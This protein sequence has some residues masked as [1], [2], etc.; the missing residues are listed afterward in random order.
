MDLSHL[1]PLPLSTFLIIYIKA[2]R[3]ANL[4]YLEGARALYN[5]LT[6]NGRFPLEQDKAVAVSRMPQIYMTWTI[7]ELA[8]I[9][10]SNGKENKVV[11]V[12]RTDTIDII[13]SHLN[14]KVFCHE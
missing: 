9:I 5:Y 13:Y 1:K 3:E 4:N 11:S 7:A 6:S 12:K 14:E 2:G 8:K 10:D